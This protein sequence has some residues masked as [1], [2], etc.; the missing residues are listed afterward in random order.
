MPFRTKPLPFRFRRATRSEL[1]AR[2]FNG[3]QNLTKLQSS[4]ESQ[5]GAGAPGRAALLLPFREVI[6]VHIRALAEHLD[7]PFIRIFRINQ[8]GEKLG[9]ATIFAEAHQQPSFV[10]ALPVGEV[11]GEMKI[12]ERPFAFARLHALRA[13]RHNQH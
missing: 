7:E 1:R 4:N 3:R 11:H 2:R 10:R 5:G 6:R 12:I 9:P 13:S 8:V